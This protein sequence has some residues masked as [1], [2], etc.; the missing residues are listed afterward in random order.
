[1]TNLDLLDNFAKNIEIE[2]IKLGYSQQEFAKLL[3]ISSST[4]K[5]IISRR[6]S[7]VDITLVPKIYS[8]TG[9]LLFELLE[10][11]SMELE[12]LKK[13]RLLTERQKAYISGK[14]DFELEMKADEK[15][16]DNMLDVLVLTGDMKDGMILDSSN[17]QRIYC[18]EY[19][20]KY[21]KKLHCGIRINSN[22]L[23]PV[24]VKGDI[25]CVSKKPPRDGDTYGLF[26]GLPNRHKYKIKKEVIAYNCQ[27][28]RKNTGLISTKP[29]RPC[30]GLLFSFPLVG[31]EWIV[32]S[33]Q[34]THEK[35][36]SKF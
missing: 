25:I 32:R 14:I 13:Y 29:A 35:N 11:D 31:N 10:L 12:I 2:R 34:R 7:S 33:C 3:N 1:M 30:D 5:N 8:L 18:P 19:I 23:T 28:L 20:K 24:Y 15:E 36:L 4:Y 21:G 26:G 16:S 6:T 27:Y 17:E 9:R 22:H